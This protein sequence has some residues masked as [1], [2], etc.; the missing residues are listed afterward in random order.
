MFHPVN[1]YILVEMPKV[2]DPSESVI[3][4]PDD[5]KPEKERF[6]EVSALKAAWDVRFDM[7][8]SAID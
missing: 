1:R 7:E 2:H 8:K 3:V 4:L 6:V 5:Y